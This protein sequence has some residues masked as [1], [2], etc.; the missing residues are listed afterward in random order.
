MTVMIHK[1]RDNATLCEEAAV[2]FSQKW[3]IPIGAYRESMEQCIAQ[4]K[5][6]PQWYVVLD[7]AKRIIAGAGVID[8]DFHD[9]TDLFPNLCALFV[10]E[11]YRHQRIARKL[12][13]FAADDMSELGYDMLYLVTDHVGLYERYGWSFLTMAT[14]ADGNATRMY[15]RKTAIL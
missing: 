9:R 5:S 3:G 15:A 1:L 10:E 4:P 6:T 12:L 8:N 13:A 7:D 11:R 14:D 2:W